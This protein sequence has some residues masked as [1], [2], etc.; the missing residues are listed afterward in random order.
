MT[1]TGTRHGEGI[2]LA[3][4]YGG[5]W[6]WT[7]TVVL[8]EPLTITMCNVVPAEHA[9][10]SVSAGPYPVMVAELHREVEE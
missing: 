10:D 8:G 4:E 6:G 9:T 2:E 1:L 7:I 3:A 5:G